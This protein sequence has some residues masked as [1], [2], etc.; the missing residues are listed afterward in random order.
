MTM[1]HA[2]DAA[3]TGCQERLG[4]SG[5]PDLMGRLKGSAITC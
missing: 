1:V 3:L 5:M 2:I 4:Q